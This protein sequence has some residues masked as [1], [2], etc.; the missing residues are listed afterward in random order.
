MNKIPTAQY[1]LISLFT[2]FRFSAKEVCFIPSSAP[3]QPTSLKFRAAPLGY[4]LFNELS[5]SSPR[6]L[7]G[8]P[9]A[10]L[11]GSDLSKLLIWL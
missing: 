1:P 9:K 3:D 8:I 2:V 6:N 7:R 5:V 4:A 11:M 10:Q